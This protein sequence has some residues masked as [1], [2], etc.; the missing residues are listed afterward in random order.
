MITSREKKRTTTTTTI[1]I[2]IIIIKYKLEYFKEIIDTISAH[3][4]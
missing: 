1:I 4:S 2:I 3:F